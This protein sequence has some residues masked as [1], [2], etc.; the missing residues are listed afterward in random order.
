MAFA[1]VRDSADTSQDTAARAH[2]IQRAWLGLILAAWLVTIAGCARSSGPSV[3]AQTPNADRSTAADMDALKTELIAMADRDQELRKK[4]MD[5]GL[6]REDRADAARQCGEVDQVHT[7][8]LKEIVDRHGWPTISMVGEDASFGAF[9][10]VQHA[11]HDP[12]FQARCLPMLEAAAEQGEVSKKALA[13]LTDRVR[14]K[15]ERPQVYGTQYQGKKDEAGN[16]ITGENGQIIY[17]VPLVEDIDRL[18]ERRRAAGLGPW[19][20]Y[21]KSMAQ[22]HKRDPVKRPRSAD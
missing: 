12:A 10:L 3:S 8:R 21:E 4:G 16:F 14:V 18:D 7:A 5:E 6:S 15:Q 1:A 17:I 22:L 20:E 9:L 2:R 19:K 13:Y 11:D